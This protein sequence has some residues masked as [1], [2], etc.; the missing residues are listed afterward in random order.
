MNLN[1]VLR[2]NLL[3]ISIL[4]ANLVQSQQV[5]VYLSDKCETPVSY[6]D[7]PLCDDYL[8]EINRLEIPII[9]TSRWLNAVC[10]SSMYAQQAATLPFVSHIEALTS[11]KVVEEKTDEVFGYGEADWQIEML[12]L[13]SFHRLG[14][15]GKG[16]RLALFDAGFYKVDSLPIFDSLWTNNQILASYDFV[17]N[18]TLT[19]RTSTHGMQVLALAGI[20]FPDSMVGG[21]PGADF[22]LARTEER[23]RERHVEELN[24]FR[25]MEWADSIGVD[26]IHSSLGYSLFDSL[27]GDYTYADMDGESTIITLAAELAASRGIFITNSAGNSGTSPWYHITAPCDG[28]NVLCIGAVDSMQM[29]ADFSSRGP[30]SDGRIKPDVAAMGKGNTIPNG[31]GILVRGSGTSFSGPLVASL[32]ACLMEANP[33]KSN[34]QIFQAILLSADRYDNPNNDYGYGI[35]NAIRADSI[36]KT[37][38]SASIK[39]L[40]ATSV[41]VYPNPATSFIKVKCEPN[42]HYTIANANGQLILEGKLSNWI[43]FIDLSPIPSGFYFIE[44][45]TNGQSTVQRF[46]KQ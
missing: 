44:V 2:I 30:S 25:A 45:L 4:L 17:T 13:D 22:V 1:K 34:G 38:G 36:L 41:A 15:T 28:K 39:P 6:F 35:P 8:T 24:W 21:S 16:V 5:W 11:L 19:W 23:E 33:T 46:S 7:A 3:V 42:S 37:M 9:G 40:A 14:Y 20:N 26:I 12:Q 31:D 43:N 10:I 29:I 32:V 27:E 18:D